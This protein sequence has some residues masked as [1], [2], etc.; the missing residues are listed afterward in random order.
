MA[1]LGNPIDVSFWNR[2]GDPL[3]ARIDPKNSEREEFGL[4][5]LAMI[6]MIDERTYG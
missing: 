6:L 4:G 2:S 3:S 1:W 5:M